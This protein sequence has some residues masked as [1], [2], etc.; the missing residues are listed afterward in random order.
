MEQRPTLD[1]EPQKQQSG[2]QF[3]RLEV[4]PKTLALCASLAGMFAIMMLGGRGRMSQDEAGRIA[5]MIL[6]GVFLLAGSFWVYI[7]ARQSKARANSPWPVLLMVVAF[8]ALFSAIVG[9]LM[10][11]RWWS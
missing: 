11:R 3:L 9:L 2:S 6:V 1:Y 7:R 5:T 10:Q 4:G 8:I